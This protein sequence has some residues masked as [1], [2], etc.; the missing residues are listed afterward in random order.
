M[1][2]RVAQHTWTLLTN[3]AAVLLTVARN[4]DARIEEIA[5]E[6]GI[7]TRAVQTIIGDLV[8][9]GYVERIRVGRRNRYRV[10]RD[11]PMRRQTFRDREVGALLA[12]L[13]GA[14][15]PSLVALAS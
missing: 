15:G 2:R 11:M 4:P 9:D 7:S 1:L 12:L 14:V 6:V 3:H 5:A 10:Q 8:A 13:A